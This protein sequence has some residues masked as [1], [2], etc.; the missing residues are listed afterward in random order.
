MN[1]SVDRFGDLPSATLGAF[2]LDGEFSCFT[3]EDEHRDVKV[4]GETRIPAGTYKV[5][6]QRAGKLHEKYLGKFPGEHQGMLTLQSVPGFTGVM[7]H[8]GNTEAHTEGCILLG[9]VAMAS[10]ELASS[11]QAYRRIY[12]KV[13]QA[14]ARGEAVTIEVRNGPDHPG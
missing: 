14:M 1:L 13:V 7:I 3:L 2:S 8:I 10:G 5:E 11:T 12:T 4:P 6:L 9:D